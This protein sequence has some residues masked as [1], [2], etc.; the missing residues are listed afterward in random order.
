M[1]TVKNK[2]Q[3]RYIKIYE[4]REQLMKQGYAPHES[5]ERTAK[6]FDV[7]I[8]TVY[9]AVKEVRSNNANS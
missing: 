3:K 1:K 4:Y 7:T 8:M 2:S 9:N 5:T 6:K